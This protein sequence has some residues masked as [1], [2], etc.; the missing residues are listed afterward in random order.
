VNNKNS[1]PKVVLDRTF[2]CLLQPGTFDNQPFGKGQQPL[3]SIP[4]MDHFDTEYHKQLHFNFS[5]TRNTQSVNVQKKCVHID[6][7]SIGIWLEPSL[8]CS[9]FGVLGHLWSKMM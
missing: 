4:E 7:L 6:I 3:Y 2:M 5:A 1:E 9:D 8:L